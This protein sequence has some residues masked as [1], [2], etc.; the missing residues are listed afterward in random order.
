MTGFFVYFVFY[1]SQFCT[2][3]VISMMV[4]VTEFYCHVELVV[5]VSLGARI[6]YV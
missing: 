2:Q 1:A 5:F 6:K 3:W 4:L